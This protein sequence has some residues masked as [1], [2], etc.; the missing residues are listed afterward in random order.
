VAHYVTASSDHRSPPVYIR[1]PYLGVVWLGGAGGTTAR[2]LVGSE[3]AGDVHLPL[4]T[5]MI[6][7]CGAFLLG[8][9]LER[10]GRSGA[11]PERRRL[12]RLFAGTGFLGGFTTYS[13]LA[14]DA[15]GLWQAGDTDL[16]VTYALGT[17]LLGAIAS[18]AG[19][20]AGARLGREKPR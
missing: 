11:E 20:A 15:V 9:L 17:V 1:P 19:I 13:A 6:N 18:L 3:I 16:A 8:V 12:V 14:T 2:Y 10:L 7:V 5:F 4:A